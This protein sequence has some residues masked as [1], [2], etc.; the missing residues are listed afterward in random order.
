[1][2]NNVQLMF[3][4][5]SYNRVAHRFSSE[6]AI[7]QNG[8][9]NVWP[10][11]DPDFVN[12]IVTDDLTL[13]SISWNFLSIKNGLS[14]ENATV[15]AHRMLEKVLVARVEQDEKSLS[16]TT[17][18]SSVLTNEYTYET[19]EFTLNLLVNRGNT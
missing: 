11:C 10:E 19:E 14:L 1:M 4:P 13:V 3:T 2:L 12:S 7:L 8:S 18:Y 17:K 5:C 6:G 16:E 15:C 9:I